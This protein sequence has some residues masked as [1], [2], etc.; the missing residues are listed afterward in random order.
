M[1]YEV[2][3]SPIGIGCGVTSRYLSRVAVVAVGVVGDQ[4][5]LMLQGGHVVVVDR[6][7][8]L[9]LCQDESP[10]LSLDMIVARSSVT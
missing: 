2:S 5:E 8:M 7:S 6:E 4:F 1:F 9:R 10:S 3:C